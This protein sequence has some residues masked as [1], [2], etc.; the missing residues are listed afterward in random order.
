MKHSF[1]TLQIL[2]VGKELLSCLLLF[3]DLGSSTEGRSALVATFSE[4]NN[5][6]E[7]LEGEKGSERGENGNLDVYDLKGRRPLLRCWGYLQKSIDSRD[8]VSTCSIEAVNALSVGCLQF[9]HDG[10]RYSPS[11]LFWFSGCYLSF[12]II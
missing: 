2:P 1:L 11:P 9:C 3:K 4:L 5:S 6:A 12:L 10:K 7:D 8:A